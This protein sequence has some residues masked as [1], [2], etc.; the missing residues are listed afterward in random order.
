[1]GA[2]G[3]AGDVGAER[4]GRDAAEPADVDGVDLA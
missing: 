4:L 1:V 2:L 3:L